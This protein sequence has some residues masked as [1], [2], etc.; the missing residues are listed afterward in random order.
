MSAVVKIALVETIRSGDSFI[1]QTVRQNYLEFQHSL[2]AD[3]PA[4]ID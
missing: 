2:S 1:V 3:C 4:Y